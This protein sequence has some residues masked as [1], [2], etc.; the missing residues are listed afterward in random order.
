[1]QNTTLSVGDPIEAR[2]TKCRKNT[3]H[4]VVAMAKEL[5]VKVECNTCSGQHKYRPPTAAKKPAVRRANQ[6]QDAER[7]EWEALVPTMNEA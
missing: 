4:I 7:K 1:M 3:N 2:C 6:P 5:P